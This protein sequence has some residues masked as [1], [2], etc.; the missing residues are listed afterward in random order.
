MGQAHK[1]AVGFNVGQSAKLP[2]LL[3]VIMDPSMVIPERDRLVMPRC[4]AHSPVDDGSAQ[5]VPPAGYLGGRSKHRH[6]DMRTQLDWGVVAPVPH[7]P[8]AVQLEQARRR[9]SQRMYSLLSMP[10]LYDGSKGLLRSQ[11]LMQ[12]QRPSGAPISHLDSLHMPSGL[13]LT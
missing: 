12:R 5:A 9:A 6:V 11:D 7:F 4:E 8:H 2:K 1:V 13:P 3:T 10:S